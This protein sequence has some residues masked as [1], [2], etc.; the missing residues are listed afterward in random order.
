MIKEIKL[1]TYIK[2][3]G[4]HWAD[5]LPENCPPEDVCVADG[6]VFY[7]LTRNKDNIVPDDW[8]NNLTLYPERK[9]N[10][11]LRVYAAGLSLFDDLEALQNKMKLPAMK[12]LGMK[13]LAKIALEPED[14]VVMPTFYESH[15]TWWRTTMCNLD[16]AELL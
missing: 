16:K 10:N 15:H 12:R 4:E 2:E 3:Y 8:Q 6:D 11:N 14:G 1:V 9:Y 5:E 13:G 7:R